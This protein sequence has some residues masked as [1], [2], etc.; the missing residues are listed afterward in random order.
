[1]L[2]KCLSFFFVAQRQTFNVCVCWNCTPVLHFVFRNK[3]GY[4]LVTWDLEKVPLL[5]NCHLLRHVSTPVC[6]AK[7]HFLTVLLSFSVQGLCNDVSC[8]ILKVA[9]YHKVGNAHLLR[10]VCLIT[11]WKWTLVFSTSLTPSCSKALVLTVPALQGR[12]WGTPKHCPEHFWPWEPNAGQQ[13]WCTLDQ[14]PV[15][16]SVPGKLWILLVVNSVS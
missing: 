3:E 1:M 15:T 16:F 13:G 5:L 7:H 6:L 12:N 2:N 11:C 9:S 14:C 4:V 8:L 10:A